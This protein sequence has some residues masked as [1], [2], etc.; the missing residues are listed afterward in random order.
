M[1][2]DLDAACT[3]MRD[4]QQTKRADG[5]LPN[6]IR[7][8]RR[9]QALLDSRVAATT[10]ADTRQAD[11]IVVELPGP[12]IPDVIDPL[13]LPPRRALG[14]PK[15]VRN[16]PLEHMPECPRCQG[17]QVKRAGLARGRQV[18]HCHDCNR[19]FMGRGFRL[20]GPTT[21]TPKLLCYRCGNTDTKNLGPAADSGRTGFCPQC[22]KRFIQG[23]RNELA[24]YHL[25]LEKRVK[26]LKL[27]KDVEAEAV[28]MAFRDVIEG[29]GYCW[30]VELRKADAFKA[31][32]GEYGQRG[33]DHPEFRKHQGQKYVED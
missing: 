2:K 32:R 5:T 10:A 27:P 17:T 31:A 18:Y 3:W 24:K 33:S 14:R 20:L 21:E 29:K 8:E 22:D 26:D 12:A 6:P 15:G 25:L 13:A 9:R 23:G 4:R 1:I 16:L 30:T 19:K 28:Q 7:S 11:A